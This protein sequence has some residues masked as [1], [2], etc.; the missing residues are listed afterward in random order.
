MRE[1]LAR[2]VA[3]LTHFTLEGAASLC[4]CTSAAAARLCTAPHLPGWDLH[5]SSNL[6]RPLIR[7]A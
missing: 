5:N 4:I 2:L 3:S 7:V 6:G 1:A